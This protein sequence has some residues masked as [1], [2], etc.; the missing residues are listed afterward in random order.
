MNLI[1]REMLFFEKVDVSPKPRK[2]RPLYCGFL[3]HL[4]KNIF[5]NFLPI[6]FGEGQQFGIGVKQRFTVRFGKTVPRTHI[7]AHIATEHPVVQFTLKFGRNFIFELNGQI[8]NTLAAIHHIGLHNGFGRAS[9][10]TG[11][12]GS[13]MVGYGSIVF[14]LQVH[15]KFS[16]KVKGAH[17]LGKEVTVF[18]DPAQATF[19]RP[20]LVQNRGRIHKGPSMHLPYFFLNEMKK[21][22]QFILYHIVIIHS[23]GILG[24]LI[25]IWILLF[26]WKVVQQKGYHGFGTFDQF[27][28]VQSF[29]KMVF[30]VLHFA[31]HVLVEPFFQTGRFLLQKSSFGNTARQKSETLGLSFD[32]LGM[33]LDTHVTKIGI[34]LSCPNQS[35][36]VLTMLYSSL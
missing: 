22:F 19:C 27:G 35:Y 28:G 29:I 14:Q 13:A 20:C 32:E 4:F 23:V 31:M 5:R 2:L 8:G 15:D 11:G 25:G 34:V 9:I 6:L 36:L 33:F 18:P 17:L 12:T 16:H 21:V 30:H 24:N 1:G 26:G 3:E 10:N 7:L